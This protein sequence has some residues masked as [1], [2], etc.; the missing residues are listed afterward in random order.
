MAERNMDKQDE[1]L[2]ELFS[3]APIADNGFSKRVLRKVRQQIWVNR[4]ALPVAVMIGFAIAF[5][6]L[7]QLSSV[8]PSLAGLVP[9]ESLGVTSLPSIDVQTLLFGGVLLFAVLFAVQAIEE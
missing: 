3:S 9:L 6:P 4:L 7:M 2:T 1:F 5:K 8:L